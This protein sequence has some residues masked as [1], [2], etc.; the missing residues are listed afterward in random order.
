MQNNIAKHQA[1]CPSALTT[2]RIALSQN[3]HRTAEVRGVSTAINA[4]TEKPEEA[5]DNRQRNTDG[6]FAKRNGSRHP[7]AFKRENHHE[8]ALRPAANS[9]R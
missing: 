7:N 5:L 1:L 4:V 6:H 9:R 2:Q 8:I 3:G